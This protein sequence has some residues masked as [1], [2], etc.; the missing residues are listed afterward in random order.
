MNIFKLVLR[1]MTRRK[2]NFLLGMLSITM[3]AAIISHSL[4][5]LAQHDFR[6]DEIIRQKEEETTARMAKLEDDYRIIMKK[7]GFNLLIIPENQNMADLYAEDFATTF[8]P[9]SFVDTLAASGQVSI[10]HLLPSIQKKMEWPEYKRT[11]ILTGTRGEVPLHQADPKEPMQ[12]PVAAGEIVLGYELHRS[13]DLSVGDRIGFMGRSFKVSGCYDER[14]SKDDITVWIELATAQEMMNKPGE[15]NAILA[16]KCMCAPDQLADLRQEIGTILPGTK[17]IEKG[18]RIITRAEARRRAKTEALAA[19]ASEKETRLKLRSEMEQF[20]AVL[21]PVVL[22]GCG[23]LIAFLFWTNVR[24][25]KSEI[26]I[27]RAIG[28]GTG[29]IL[30]LFIVRAGIMGLLG[31]LTGLLIGSIVI[32][33]GEIPDH[34]LF[35]QVVG[36]SLFLALTGAWIPSYAGVSRDPALVLMED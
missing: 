8:M 32:P 12:D 33:G 19:I 1:E 15:I 23:L 28:A 34:T 29:K 2:M 24:E 26:G 11:V 35:L 31:G 14:G 21:I 18:S 10:R 30:S 27:L 9:E 6:T 17:L 36:I 7:M 16:L 22:A 4:L 5:S 13:L 25:R 3:A 20:N